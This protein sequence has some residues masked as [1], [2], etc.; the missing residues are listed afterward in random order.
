MF[1]RMS[2]SGERQPPSRL[3]KQSEPSRSKKNATRS[4]RYGDSRN[5]AVERHSS[6]I[7]KAFDM[8][9]ACGSERARLL[10]PFKIKNWVLQ[11][12]AIV[13]AI[14]QESASFEG[15]PRPAKKVRQSV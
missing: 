11:R 9:E 1:E 3:V 2:D 14:Q 12:P 6:P 10:L 15:R 4:N 13:V 8:D 7:E 5:R